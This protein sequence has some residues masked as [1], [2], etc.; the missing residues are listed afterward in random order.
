MNRAGKRLKPVEIK[1]RVK[2]WLDAGFDM[3]ALAYT[4]RDRLLGWRK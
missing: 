4:A 1:I 2:F 3:I